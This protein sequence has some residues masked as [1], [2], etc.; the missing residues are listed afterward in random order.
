MLE[1]YLRHQDSKLR[2]TA[3]QNPASPASALQAAATD[4]ETEV[5]LSV[6]AKPNTPPDTLMHLAMDG[7][8][9]VR[10]AV[11]NN[12]QASEEMKVLSIFGG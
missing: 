4:P 12:P 6:A 2:I 1:R 5:R 3:L 10:A 7:E 9:A 11:R 8:Q